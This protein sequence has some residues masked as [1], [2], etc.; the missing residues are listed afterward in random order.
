MGVYKM[1]KLLL[2]PLLFF[3]GC[4]SPLDKIDKN[5]KKLEKIEQ[6]VQKTDELD[7]KI[8]D[9]QSQINS[10]KEELKTQQEAKQNINEIFQKLASFNKELKQLKNTSKSKID[11]FDYIVIH[12]MTLITIKDSNIYSAPSKSAKIVKIYP[13]AT[14]FTT[15]KEKNGF[16][17]VTGYF[18]NNKW[19]ENKNEW[20]ICK[21]DTAVK[22]LGE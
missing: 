11:Y 1:K 4:D 7:V 3:I 8:K 2:L 14:T 12:P 18:V 22:R 10:L 19:V 16:V 13:K 15:Y 6:K 17:K 21:K 5:S 9:L 20:W